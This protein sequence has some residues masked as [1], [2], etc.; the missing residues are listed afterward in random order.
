VRRGAPSAPL[1][2]VGRRLIFSQRSASG[3]GRTTRVLWREAIL[4][5]DSIEQSQKRIAFYT[6]VVGAWIETRMERDRAILTLSSAAIG[7]LVTILTTMSLPAPWL[8]Y[9]Y[10][11]ASGGFFV[12]CLTCVSVFSRNARHLEEI[13]QERSGIGEGLKR[14][15][16]VSAVSFGIGVIAFIVIGVSSAYYKIYSQEGSAV[17]KVEHKTGGQYSSEGTK[18]LSGIEKLSPASQEKPATPPQ[19]GASP[20][21]TSTP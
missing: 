13:A 9:A 8:I 5:D 17:P 10:A 7:L 15:D 2:E 20:E 19:P 6:Q 12:A 11:I 3:A 1:D 21:P 16:F 14:H 4:T 18:S